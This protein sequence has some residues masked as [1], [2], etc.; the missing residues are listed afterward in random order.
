MLFLSTYRTLALEH[1]HTPTISSFKDSSAGTFFCIA[2][3]FCTT[4]PLCLNFLDISTFLF[5]FEAPSSL[6]SL[7]VRPLFNFPI[8]CNIN[9][10]CNAARRISLR[11]CVVWLNEFGVVPLIATWIPMSQCLCVHAEQRRK[12]FYRT[13]SVRH[14]I[15]ECTCSERKSFYS[16]PPCPVCSMIHNHIV[17]IG[18]MD[19]HPCI[20]TKIFPSCTSLDYAIIIIIIAVIVIII[21]GYAHA[22]AKLRLK[23]TVDFRYFCHSFKFFCTLFFSS[24][25]C[26]GILR[27]ITHFVRCGSHPASLDYRYEWKVSTSV[28]FFYAGIR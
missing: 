24:F 17:E 23:R 2:A 12:F 8:P 15:R 25:P 10:V 28:C 1:I 26:K 9:N 4:N 21:I 16:T 11:M 7:T 5:S 14:C 22:L 18:S 6:L 13:D 19:A 20:A 3:T 27:L